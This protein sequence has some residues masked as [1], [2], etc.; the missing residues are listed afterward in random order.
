MYNL[1]KIGKEYCGRNR[2]TT[3][4]F[5]NTQTD[6]KKKL[7]TGSTQCIGWTKNTSV[8]ESFMRRPV[9]RTAFRVGN[10]LMLLYRGSAPAYDNRPPHY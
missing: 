5:T 1:V 8:T 2:S 3:D 10:P 9:D 6:G 4:L 7:I